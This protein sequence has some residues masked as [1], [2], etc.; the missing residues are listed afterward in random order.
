MHGMLDVQLAGFVADPPHVAPVKNRPEIWAKIRI[1]LRLPGR[2]VDGQT[3]PG[4]VRYYTVLAFGQLAN[5]VRD[6]R[7]TVGDWVIVRAADV[8][9]GRVWIDDQRK[10]RSGGVEFIAESIDFNPPRE[11]VAALVAAARDGDRT[12][13]EPAEAPAE[14]PADLAEVATAG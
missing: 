8:R 13:A 6:A 11:L 12:P 4:P 14:V 7:L 2:E 10:P 3:R 5:Q 1:S 9:A